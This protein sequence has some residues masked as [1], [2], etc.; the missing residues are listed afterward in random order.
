MAEIWNEPN[1]NRYWNRL[2]VVGAHPYTAQPAGVLIIL[3]RIRAVMDRYGDAAKPVLATEITWPSS[4]GR[5][6]APFPIGTSVSGQAARLNALMPMLE[7]ARAK[8]GLTGFYWYTW[9]SDESAA[10][11]ADP[12]TFAGLLDDS[13]GVVRAKP[14]LAVFRRWALRLEGCSMKGASAGRC[15]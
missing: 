5:T 13:S 9:M 10:R 8:L 4:A 6:L 1:F 14:A 11:A 15:G 2:D 12:F 7:S 3:H